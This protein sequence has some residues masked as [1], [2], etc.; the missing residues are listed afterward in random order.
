MNEQL[1]ILC[2]NTKITNKARHYESL[3]KE[4]QT[5][6]DGSG[7]EHFGLLSLEGEEHPDPLESLE[8]VL[9]RSGNSSQ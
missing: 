7:E 6:S 4:I 1:G 2:K 9:C 3:N 5:F 8:K